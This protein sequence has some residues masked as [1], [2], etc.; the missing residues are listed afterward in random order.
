MKFKSIF[1]LHILKVK[2][3]L[4]I[5]VSKRSTLI[6]IDKLEK[7]AYYNMFKTALT[8]SINK[9]FSKRMKK[10]KLLLYIY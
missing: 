9:L 5:K 7:N 8:A 10:E 1:Y 3:L 6:E 2:K 4:T